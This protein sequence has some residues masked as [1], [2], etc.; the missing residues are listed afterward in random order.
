MSKEK[1]IEKIAKR[2][3]L[4]ISSRKEREKIIGN[5]IEAMKPYYSEKKDIPAWNSDT[6]KNDKKYD[7]GALNLPFCQTIFH[8]F[9]ADCAWHP[10]TEEERI[11]YFWSD[12]RV[13]LHYRIRM[14]ADQRAIDLLIK[15]FGK[16]TSIDLFKR[17]SAQNLIVAE[18]LKE[19]VKRMEE[20]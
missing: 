12:V 10:K 9:H 8:H 19:V 2:S 4:R 6:K 14:Y 18:Y 3:Q 5:F 1:V 7:S 16:E 11:Y 17:W 20:E 13:R 15:I